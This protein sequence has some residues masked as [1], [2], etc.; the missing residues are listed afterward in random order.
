MSRREAPGWPEA[1]HGTRSAFQGVSGDPLL[2]LTRDG[3]KG[4]KVIK[5]ER[6]PI[7]P[8]PGLILERA[9]ESR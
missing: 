3:E 4:L 5:T 8:C 7:A 1:S 2:G 6:G 9:R